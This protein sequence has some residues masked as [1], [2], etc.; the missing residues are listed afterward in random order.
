MRRQ[1]APSCPAWRVTVAAHDVPPRW[2]VP[3]QVVKVYAPDETTAR[4][5]AVQSVARDA[6]LPPWKPALRVV[7]RHTAAARVGARAA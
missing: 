7:Y 5:L 4:V 3:A 2:S 6:D 1:R